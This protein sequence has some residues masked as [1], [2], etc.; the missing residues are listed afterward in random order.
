MTFRQFAF[1]NV[2]RNKRVYIGHFL[3]STF[4]VIIFFTFGLIAYHPALEGNITEVNATMNTLGKGGFQVSQYI[5]YIFSIFFILYSVSSFLKKRK[6]EFGIL[7]ILGLSPRQFTR[8]V[9]YENIIIGALATVVGI[10][11]GLIF[12][13]LILLIS[14]SVLTLEKGLP[15]YFPAKAITTTGI[16]FMLL[17]VLISFFTSKTVRVSKLVDLIKSEEKPKPA[18]RASIW[19]AVFAVILIM[20]GY[21]VVFYFALAL[22]KMSSTEMFSYMAVVVGLVVL[23]TYFLFT[24]LSVYFL[25]AMKQRDRL[26]FKKTNILSISELVYR[27]KDNAITFFLVAVIS[28]VAFTAIGTSSAVGEVLLHQLD[29][30]Y[31][32][33]YDSTVKND[34]EQKHLIEIKKE[35]EKEKIPYTLI[36]TSYQV[37]NQNVMKLSEYNNYAKKLGYK[38]SLLENENE[39]IVIQGLSSAGGPKKGEAVQLKQGLNK[40]QIRKV[41]SN[42]YFANYM[43]CFVIADSLYT[44]MLKVSNDKNNQDLTEHH[45]YGFLIKDWKGT[46][47]LA[48]KLSA[49]ID[50]KAEHPDYFV[51]FLPIQWQ[52]LKQFN[53]IFSIL[54]VLVGIVFFVFAS[55][56]LYFRL[57][58]DLEKDQEKYRMLSKLG[59][60]K[61]E[62]NRV[63]TREMGVLF[64]LPFIVA[65]I[66][67]SVAFVALQQLVGRAVGNISLTQNFEFVLVS[68]LIFHLVYF[69]IMRRSY[70]KQ[71]YRAI[72]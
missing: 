37:L 8:L 28:A 43:P 1:N 6:K 7:M 58:T 3:S 40:V 9:F 51:S 56:F 71:L 13:K 47:D 42:R 35:L 52:Y 57:F 31:A 64:F 33:K 21:L 69:F 12:S 48:E 61:K 10:G 27:I 15:F 34:L 18:P 25:K 32:I 62:L 29:L 5:I 23:G 24:Q 44:E 66:H 65:V 2:A 16:S 26:F 53:G 70:L 14:A 11:V 20:A 41:I 50:S 36:S 55:S 60:S 17:F 67:S 45:R 63:V 19:L 68:F 38:P 59:L 30:T 4:A 46:H 49:N 22:N 54:T 72:F 39:A